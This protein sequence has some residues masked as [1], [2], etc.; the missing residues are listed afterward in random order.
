MLTGPTAVGGFVTLW[1]EPLVPWRVMKSPCCADAGLFIENELPSN[2]TLPKDT[3]TVPEMF[4]TPCRSE[5]LAVNGRLTIAI[6][7][8][9]ITLFF[10]SLSRSI[11]IAA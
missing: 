8:N 5:A 1:I 6:R 3:S 7:L 10:I 4:S 11:A 9:A 2:V